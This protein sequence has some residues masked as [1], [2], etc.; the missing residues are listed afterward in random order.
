M[1]PKLKKILREEI[2]RP[3]CSPGPIVGTDV[4]LLCEFSN[5]IAI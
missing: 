1:K 3:C 4:I 5:V 2:S